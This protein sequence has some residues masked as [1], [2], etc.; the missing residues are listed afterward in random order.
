[1][2]SHA[3]LHCGKVQL[4]VVRVGVQHLGCQDQQGALPEAQG[5]GLVSA[6]SM[7]SGSPLSRGHQNQV[8]F[9]PPPVASV[10]LSRIQNDRPSPEAPRGRA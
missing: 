3:E 10:V 7:D 4:T 2:R 5:T 6:Q 8:Y 1:M 9:H